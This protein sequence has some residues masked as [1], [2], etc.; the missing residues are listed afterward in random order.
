MFF[1]NINFFDYYFALYAITL[2]TLSNV[3]ALHF[4]LLTVLHKRL[5]LWISNGIVLHRW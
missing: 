1:C 4:S 5:A 2:Y 3:I